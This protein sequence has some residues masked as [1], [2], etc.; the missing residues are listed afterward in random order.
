M[1]SAKSLFRYLHDLGTLPFDPTAKLI[2]PRR[3]RLEPR[4]LSGGEYKRL[5][6]SST[7]D[8]RDAAVIELI[9]QAGIR[10][11]EAAALRTADIELPAR[12][13]REGPPSAVQV[14]GKGRK[15]RTVNGELAGLQGPEG[16]AGG[17]A[18][19]QGRRAVLHQ[20]SQAA[21]PAG[22]PAP[23]AEA[24]ARGGDHGHLG[25]QPRHYP[26]LAGSYWSTISS[27]AGIAA[28]S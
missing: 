9:L 12:V 16:V 26:M 13:T 15:E 24:P 6:L 5:Q 7:H 8:V 3:E 22:H 4:V 14:H 27:E 11:S 23:G 28:M 20:V 18:D 17:P 25:A 1:A 10:L 19:Q 21:R 2:P